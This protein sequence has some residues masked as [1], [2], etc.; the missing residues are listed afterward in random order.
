MPSRLRRRVNVTPIGS[1]NAVLRTLA[2]RYLENRD[3]CLCILDADRRREDRDNKRRVADYAERRFRTSADEMN[4]WIAA[5]QAYLPSDE[6]PERWLIASCIEQGDKTQLASLWC[7]EDEGS[8]D[9]WLAA[10]LREQSRDELHTL[11]RLAQLPVDQIVADLIRFLCESRPQMW[12]EII[13]LV[14]RRLS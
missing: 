12:G 1:S 8:I 10:A 7:E 3:N 5:R 11:S 9:A 13:G 4:D 14:E 2:S 6:T